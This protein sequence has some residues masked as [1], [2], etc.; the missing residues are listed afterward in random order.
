ML[1]DLELLRPEELERKEIKSIEDVVEALKF[2]KGLKPPQT[3]YKPPYDD[4]V[5]NTFEMINKTSK[6]GLPLL[7]FFSKT[8]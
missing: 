3:Y 2:A 1:R 5:R 4:I 7:F 6:V 8:K